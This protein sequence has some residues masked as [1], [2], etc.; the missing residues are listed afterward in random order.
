M[1]DYQLFLIQILPKQK[2]FSIVLPKQ[3]AE[4]L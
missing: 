1:I 2:Y 3:I 4:I